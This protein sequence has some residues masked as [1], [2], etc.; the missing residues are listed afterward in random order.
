MMNICKRY[1]VYQGTARY[2]AP[3]V[4][5]NLETDCSADIFSLAIIMW[6]M[7]ENRIPYGSLENETIIWNVVRNNMRPDSLKACMD[8]NHIVKKSRKMVETQHLSKSESS[9]MQ[10]KKYISLPLT[11]KTYNRNREKVPEIFINK[12]LR[13][14]EKSSYGS[15]QK[16]RIFKNNKHF[17]IRKKLFE[18]KLSPKLEGDENEEAT[19]LQ[20]L[21]VDHQLCLR[22]LEDILF[23]ESEYAKMYS[24]C[25]SS[26]KSQRYDAFKVFNVLQRLINS[27]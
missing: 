24:D 22:S 11:P 7:K 8:E 5:Q 6:Q 2:C 10:V 1:I 25:W 14:T 18:S 17:L 21:F 16:N 3:E 9:F 23:V 15:H 20:E 27:L 26:E 19:D 4:L 13:L 12:P